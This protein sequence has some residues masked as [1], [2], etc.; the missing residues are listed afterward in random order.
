MKP[1]TKRDIEHIYR[2]LMK[3]AHE[4][5]E[6]ARGS[7]AVHDV[8]VAAE[9]AYHFNLFYA[10][11]DAEQLLRTIA[12]AH[13]PHLQVPGGDD[14]RCVLIDSYCL[15]NRG[16]IQQYLRAILKCDMQLLYVCTASTTSYGHDILKELH[17]DSQ[18]KILLLSEG[19]DDCLESGV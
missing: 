12:D 19:I 10:D 13:I 2:Q 8:R 7:Q 9:W 1:Y 5:A 4:N 6:C 15:D 11:P 16:L 17:A 18:A 3:R 14:N